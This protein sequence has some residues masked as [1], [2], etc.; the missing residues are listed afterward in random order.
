MYLHFGRAKYKQLNR[1][2]DRALE[3][4]KNRSTVKNIRVVHR[5]SVQV[6]GQVHVPGLEQ[7]PAFAQ[8]GVQ[9]AE[10]EKNILNELCYSFYQS[11]N[12]LQSIHWYM[13]KFLDSNNTDLSNMPTD[14]LLCSV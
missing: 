2:K 7:I 6:A 14:K 1:K 11:N 4:L 10:Y 13:N 5:E 8:I 9:T 12:Q 3:I